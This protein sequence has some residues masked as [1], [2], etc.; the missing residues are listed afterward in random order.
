MIV[1]V[2]LHRWRLWN[3]GFN[4]S[5]L[6]AREL[7]RRSG[8]ASD[9]FAL[10]RTQ[11]WSENVIHFAGATESG[12]L[13]GAALATGDFDGD[14]FDDLAI[15]MPFE[16]VGGLIRAGAVN[17]LRGSAGG[18]SAVGDQLWHQ[19]SPG[20]LDTAENIDDFGFALI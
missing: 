9:P 3:R 10:A 8:I 1:P 14:G 16:N 18:L 13:L 2:P 20:V 6:V 7:S 17:L 12:D 19:D 4:Q 15:G 11:V 5:A